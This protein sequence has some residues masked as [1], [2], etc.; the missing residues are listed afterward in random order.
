MAPQEGPKAGR[1]TALAMSIDGPNDGQLVKQRPVGEVSSIGT[2]L[3]QVSTQKLAKDQS[4]EA[5][6]WPVD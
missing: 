4:M 6:G 3:G 5:K 1:D 2:Y